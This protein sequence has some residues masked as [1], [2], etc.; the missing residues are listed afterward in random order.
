MRK[1]ITLV[2]T[3]IV[4]TALAT[5]VGWAA[6]RQVTREVGPQAPLAVPPSD[7]LA[8]M[9]GD[10]QARPTSQPEPP[11]QEDPTSPG[12]TA[13]PSSPP[14][15]SPIEP[16]VPASQVRSHDLVGGTVTIR[17]GA[18]T[19]ELVAATPKSGFVAEVRDSGPGR[20]EVRFRSD[21]HESRFRAEG[22]ATPTIEERAD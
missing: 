9:A 22:T 17:S 8:A 7:V 11:P 4:A 19:V 2:V 10:R 20:V 6:V 12:R 16:T 13:A 5:A 14:T 21:G 1:P 18:E 15:G 3:W